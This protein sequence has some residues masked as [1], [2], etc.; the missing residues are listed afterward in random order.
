VGALFGA[1][2]RIVEIDGYRVDLDPHKHLMLCPHINRPGVIGKVGS[3]MG[4]SNINISGMQVGN[5]DIEGTNLMVLTLDNE[6]PANVL[7]E[8][9]ALDGIFG[10]KV[11]DL[12]VI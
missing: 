12:N 9:T 2:G 6:V 10:A 7:K 1:E 8:V 11:I 5:T 3:I 4:A